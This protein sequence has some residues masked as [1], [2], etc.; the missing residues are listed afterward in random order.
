MVGSSSARAAVWK[1]RWLPMLLLMLPGAGLIVASFFVEVEAME[2]GELHPLLFLGMLFLAIIIGLMAV[3]A[4]RGRATI[5]LIRNGVP[6]EVEVLDIEETGTRVN[7]M[8]VVS[9]RLLFTD[10]S[11][12]AREVEHRQMLSRLML[13]KI[14]RGD[15]LHVRVHP[16]RPEKFALLFGAGPGEPEGGRG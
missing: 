16:K 1:V 9:L 3:F 13:I 4:L 10:G 11:G 7:D 8:P 12:H 2:E 6:A 14:E 15:T 5:R